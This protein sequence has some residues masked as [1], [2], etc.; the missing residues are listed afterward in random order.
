[1]TTDKHI[2]IYAEDDLDDLFLVKQAFET[3]NHI[4]VIHAADGHQALQMLEDMLHKKTLPCLVILDVN[5]P[6]LNGRET[7]QAIRNHP[8]LGRLPVVLFTTSNNP[9]DIAFA[10]GLNASFITKPIDYRDL[11]NIAKTFVEKCNFETGKL[12][13]N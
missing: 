11:E 3:H 7:L 1:M 10:K 8:Q 9:A 2:I 12:S 13:L 5:M 6:V 4:E